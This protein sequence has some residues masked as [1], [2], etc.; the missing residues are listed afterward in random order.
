MSDMG[1]TPEDRERL[2]KSKYAEWFDELFEERFNTMFEKRAAAVRAKTPAK[3]E[4]SQPTG[5]SEP[6]PSKQPGKKRSLLEVALSQT[7]GF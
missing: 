6:Q 4:P 1:I 2:A 3:A 5:E 7:F